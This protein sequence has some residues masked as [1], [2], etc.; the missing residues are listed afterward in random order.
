MPQKVTLDK[1]SNI[2]TG[3]LISASKKT[4]NEPQTMA[5]LMCEYS[6]T[7]KIPQ[8]GTFIEGTISRVNPKE[9]RVN[10]GG[11][12]DGIIMNKEL[13]LF[14]DLVSQLKVGDKVRVYVV[15]GENLKGQLILSIRKFLLDLKWK[16]FADAMNAQEMV[17][18]RTLE[19]N[20]GGA[21][22]NAEGL[23]GFLPISQ[24][25]PTHVSNLSWYVNRLIP[26]K[27]I[28]VNQ[29]ENRLIFSER[30]AALVI[31]KEKAEELKRL[32]VEDQIYDADVV[33]ITDFGAFVKV[34]LV[35][36]DEQST[37]DKQETRDQKQATEDKKPEENI[38][39]NLQSISVNQSDDKAVQTPIQVVTPQ[40]KKKI[41]GPQKQ[42]MVDGLVHISE[43]SWDKV[44]DVNAFFKIGDK[45]KLKILGVDDRT[46]KLNC[47]VKRLTDDPWAAIAA[48]FEVDEK[49]EGKVSRQTDFGIFVQLPGNI[50]GLIHISKVPPGREFKTGEKIKCLVEAIDA[51]HRKISLSPIIEGKFVGYR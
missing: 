15:L 35:Y 38:S 49:V 10:V 32:I 12:I 13:E 42:M 43:I 4:P 22:C 46:G 6:S 31:N 50:E 3:D 37:T 7:M 30:L 39:V 19:I 25:D 45:I 34:H 14:K 40:P 27:P 23:Q 28:E 16:R 2:S 29:R 48:N 26:A 20:K 41:K 8:R 11:K 18:I 36:T 5:E 44:S 51:R 21:I 17:T 24:M 1:S 33:G 47:S 9:V